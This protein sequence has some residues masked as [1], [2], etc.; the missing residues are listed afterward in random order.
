MPVG[1]KVTLRG[2]KMYDFLD[3]LFLL[4]YQELEI[5]EVLIL[6]DLMEEVIII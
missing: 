6:K 2:D 4:L 5:L 3:S 1:T